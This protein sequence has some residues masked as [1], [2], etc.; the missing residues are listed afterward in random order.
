M[1][2]PSLTNI[3]DGLTKPVPRA[4]LESQIAAMDLKRITMPSNMQLSPVVMNAADQYYLFKF[5]HSIQPLAIDSAPW[6]PSSV[7]WAV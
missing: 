7:Q 4:A 6:R 2:C 3:A 1:F 5:W